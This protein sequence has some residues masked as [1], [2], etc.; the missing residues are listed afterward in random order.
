MERM[1]IFSFFL[2]LVLLT[3][4]QV[5][6]AQAQST[7]RISYTVLFVPES[8]GVGPLFQS[9][10]LPEYQRRFYWNNIKTKSFQP[11]SFDL[12]KMASELTQ[13]GIGRELMAYWWQRQDNGSFRLDTI[14]KRGKGNGRF[15]DD[16]IAKVGPRGDAELADQGL[17]L[18]SKSFVIVVRPTNLT[19]MDEYYRALEI[20]NAQKKAN[21]KVERSLRGYQCELEA[22]VFQLKYDNSTKEAFYDMWPYETDD[23]TT[24]RKK[25]LSF[26]QYPFELIPIKAYNAK[27]ISKS[28]FNSSIYGTVPYG[29]QTT[30][31]PELLRKLAQNSINNVLD[32]IV[33]KGSFGTLL[34]DNQPILAEIG[35]RD[36]VYPE[37][38]YAIY[39]SIERADG[40]LDKK[41]MALVRASN[42]LAKGQ[43]LYTEFYRV[44]GV[45]A[46]KPGMLIEEFK[47]KGFAV[48]VLQGIKQAPIG[49]QLGDFGIGVEG[50]LSLLTTKA[51][52]DRFP[53]GL[54]LGANLYFAK[55]SLKGV[56][57][58][59]IK[60]S[61]SRFVFYLK[62]DFHLLSVFR[63]GLWGGYGI[64]SVSETLEDQN[65]EAR[66]LST[67][68]FPCGTELGLNIGWGVL[69]F[70]QSEFVIPFGKVMLEKTERPDLKW[71][72][73]Y[74]NRTGLALRAGIRVEF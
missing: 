71:A 8:K 56:S 17:G 45:G 21:T 16:V 64:D 7:D 60:G 61:A 30:P 40:K 42:K 2:T 63:L 70:A 44:A 55:D 15:K 32:A 53:N 68:L 57:N 74:A 25:K 62:K 35:T 24:F 23:Q 50:N 58:E 11:S 51:G 6:T 5:A 59:P 34:K 4:L 22:Y 9:Q 37:K 33:G 14:A 49:N 28:L 48:H 3:G 73:L 31:Y 65:A 36:G 19:T 67:A 47:D 43:S 13:Q 46:V 26:E 12:D 38:R 54:K 10:I 27:A 72:D 69:A 66:T 52:L 18:I 29:D 41:R 20:E 39:E 1:K